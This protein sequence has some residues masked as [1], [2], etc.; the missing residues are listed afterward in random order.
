MVGAVCMFVHGREEGDGLS[1]RERGE[2]E[3]VTIRYDRN[4]LIKSYTFC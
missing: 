1:E 4:I 3:G 2:C